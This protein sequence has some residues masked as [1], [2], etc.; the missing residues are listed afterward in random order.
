MKWVL[1]GQLS[2]KLTYYVDHIKSGQFLINLFWN[3]TWVRGHVNQVLDHPI[4]INKVMLCIY[5]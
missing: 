3:P 2:H 5:F 1:I 4:E